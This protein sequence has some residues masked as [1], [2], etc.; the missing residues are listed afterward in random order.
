[1]RLVSPGFGAKVPPQESLAL[2]GLATT[3]PLGN[4]S[5]NA[6]PVS[7]TVAFGLV[8]VNVSVVVWPIGTVADPNALLIVGGARTIIVAVLLAN[9]VPPLDED[10]A[11]VMLLFTPAATPVTSTVT[12]QVPDAATVPPLKVIELLPAVAVTIPPQLVLVFGLLATL[13]PAGRESVNPTPIKATVEFGLVIVKVT[14]AVPPNG[15]VGA[16]NALLMLP[17]ATTVTVAVLLVDPVPVSFEVIAPDVLFITPAAVPVT[18]TMKLHEPP[19]AID[20]PESVIVLPP[21]TAT[22]PP[23]QVENDPFGTVSPAGRV[24]V[25][26]TPV[27]PSVALVLVIVKVRLVVPPNGIVKA[28]NALARVGGVATVTVAVLLVVPVPPFVELTAAVV[29]FFTPPVAPVTVKLILH[30]PFAATV[31]PDNVITFEL[32]ASVPPH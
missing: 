4:V 10:R 20:P 1:M 18:V 3:N 31:A 14:V 23:P 27:I 32:I 7:A 24:S 13:R 6:T 8:R 9:P 22:E 28:P 21:V 15:T 29:L 25:N 11:L 19:A 17:G 16:L 2:A 5:V 30:V 12:V 26:P